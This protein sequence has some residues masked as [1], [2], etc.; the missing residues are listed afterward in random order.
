ITLS[1]EPP[2]V[3]KGTDTRDYVM[4]PC[5]GILEPFVELGDTVT[6]GDV[7]AQIHNPEDISASATEVRAE[8][9]GMIMCRRS[10]PLTSQ[11]EVVVTLVREV[12]D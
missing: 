7:I 3:V 11:G 9:D 12:Q 8:T 5:S 10:N 2:V 6:A 1:D 4:A